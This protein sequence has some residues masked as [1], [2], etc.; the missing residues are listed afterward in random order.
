MVRHG[1]GRGLEL[2]DLNARG[3]WGDGVA[4]QKAI[5]KAIVKATHTHTV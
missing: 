5:I 3:S 2:P 1:L 4:G